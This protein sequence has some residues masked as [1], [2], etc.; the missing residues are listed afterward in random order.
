MISLQLIPGLWNT[1]FLAVKHQAV[2]WR[3]RFEIDDEG[4]R[5]IKDKTEAL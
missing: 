5:N 4:S 2:K 1:Q 3:T